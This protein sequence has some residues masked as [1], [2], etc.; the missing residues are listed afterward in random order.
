MQTS[1]IQ[2]MSERIRTVPTMLSRMNF[3]AKHKI[4]KYARSETNRLHAGMARER[5][6]A[7]F[8]FECQNF[9]QQ[10]EIS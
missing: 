1:G 4:T 9:Q 8:V 3:S 6:L 5:Q 7:C 10:K 2:M